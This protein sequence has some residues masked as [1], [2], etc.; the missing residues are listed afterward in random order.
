[1]GVCVRSTTGHRIL[2][3]TTVHTSRNTLSILLFIFSRS[4][5]SVFPASLPLTVPNLIAYVVSRCQPEV[6]WR[7]ALSVCSSSCLDHNRQRALIR[8][9]QSRIEARFLKAAS[10][11]HRD[12]TRDI[13]RREVTRRR[14]QQHAMR[15]LLALISSLSK[16]A[17]VLML[18]RV[19]ETILL[20][21]MLK[22]QLPSTT[23]SRQISSR[24]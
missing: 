15:H 24:L 2:S 13:L 18:D 20:E 23:A 14:L 8:L 16:G 1:M 5:S 11:Q 17:H 22:R 7:L 12:T 10:R 6:S 19:R 9:S 3:R 21:W 4:D